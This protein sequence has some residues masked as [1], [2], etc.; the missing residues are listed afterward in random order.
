MRSPAQRLRQVLAAER[1]A[2]VHEIDARGLRDFDQAKRQPR[3][4]RRPHPARTK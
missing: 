1:A 3:A 4:I 2:V